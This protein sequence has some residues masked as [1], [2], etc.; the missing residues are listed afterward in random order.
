MADLIDEP[1]GEE[2]AGVDG[3][4]AGGGAN[5]GHALGQ[6]AAGAEVGEDDV[7]DEIEER[8]ADL[9]AVAGLTGDVE[10]HHLF[11]F[12]CQPLAVVCADPR[13]PKSDGTRDTIR[14]MPELPDITAYLSALEARIL[15]QKL[16][17]VRLAS[18]TLLRTAQTAAGERERPRG[19]RAAA[20]REE[21]CDWTGRRTFG[22]CC[23]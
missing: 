2:C 3:V 6:L 12:R 19:A 21:D 7:A 17:Q 15:G 1:H 9:V 8:I 13:M 5:L 10:F 4:E 18:F 14:E 23:I 22:W 16:E 20:D 11:F